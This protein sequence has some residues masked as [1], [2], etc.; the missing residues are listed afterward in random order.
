MT[1]TNG[2]AIVFLIDT[3]ILYNIYIHISKLKK[4]L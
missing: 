1:T 4:K 3:Y 2:H